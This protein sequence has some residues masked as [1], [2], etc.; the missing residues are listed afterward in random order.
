MCNEACIDIITLGVFNRSKV[1]C[2]LIADCRFNDGFDGDKGELLCVL[3]KVPGFFD[4]FED[5]RP[6]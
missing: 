4:T 5:W 1:T 6:A 2:D 3:I